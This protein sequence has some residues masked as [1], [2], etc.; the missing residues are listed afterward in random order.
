MPWRTCATCARTRSPAHTLTHLLCPSRPS[1]WAGRPGC[2]HLVLQA[3]RECRVAVARCVPCGLAG[4]VLQPACLPACHDPARLPCCP[5]PQGVRKGPF[6]AHQL[7]SS[8][9]APEPAAGG[10]PPTFDQL[11]SQPRDALVQHGTLKMFA[12]LWLVA[13]HYALVAR[14]EARRWGRG[15]AGRGGGGGASPARQRQARLRAHAGRGPVLG[16]HLAWPF[17][18]PGGRVRAAAHGARCVARCA[19]RA[20]PAT[21]PLTTTPTWPRTP[22]RWRRWRPASRRACTRC[23][24]RP[25][26]RWGGRGGCALRAGWG[27]HRAVCACCA[28]LRCFAARSLPPAR[29]RAPAALRA[30]VRVWR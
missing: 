18:A 12:P 2:R 14:G 7:R 21:R 4:L 1:H 30:C 5:V 6:S 8:M 9:D 3:G 24:R 20:C 22:R 28:A 11:F 29:G 26:T 27:A 10:P 16:L 19:G 17:G 15:G 25:A 23:A 13:E